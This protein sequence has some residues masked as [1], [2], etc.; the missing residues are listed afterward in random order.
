MGKRKAIKILFL[1]FVKTACYL[2]QNKDKGDVTFVKYLTIYK[3]K[4]QK[5]QC[6]NNIYT[7]LG[8]DKKYICKFNI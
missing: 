2:L 7:K 3:Y 6:I 4:L 1:L 8:R 5:F